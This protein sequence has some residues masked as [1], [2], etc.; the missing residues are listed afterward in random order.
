MNLPNIKENVPLSSFSTIGI[1]GPAKHLI[2]AKTTEDLA[3]AVQEAIKSQTSYY[4]LGNGSNT[5]ISDSGFEGLVIL[6]L[7]SGI[8]VLDKQFQVNRKSVSARLEQAHAQEFYTFKGLDF[9]E[10]AYPSVFVEMDSGVK[11]QAGIYKLIAQGI[12]GLQWFSGIP[13]TI[14]GGVFMNVHGGP[15]FLSDFFI[16]ANIL[17][18]QGVR[19]EKS[20][21]YFKFDYDYSILHDTRDIV[22]SAVFELKKGD[23]TKALKTAQEWAKRKSIQPQ[24]SLGSTFQNISISEKERLGFPTTAAGYIID[25]VLGFKGIKRVGDA[26]VSPRHANFIENVGRATA[27]DVYQIIQEI[28]LL[29]RQKLGIDLKEE[30]KY[31]G[32]F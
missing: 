32:K 4:I 18:S 10:S 17:N 13:G 15:K 26:I 2:E 23:K 21:D 22:L 20:W 1:G 5:L 14:G 30:I 29:T 3:N 24:K 16:S 27:A 6:N 28:K 8:T 7:T 9:D 11:L 25:K 12:T 31:L 19:E